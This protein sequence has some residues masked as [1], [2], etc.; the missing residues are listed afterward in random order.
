M[1][2]QDFHL[3][4]LFVEL[5]TPATEEERRLRFFYMVQRTEATVFRRR[6]L[7]AGDN[8]NNAAAQKILLQR[9]TI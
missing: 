8:E 1:S 5:S 9:L 4:A 6:A 7:D 2:A 3:S